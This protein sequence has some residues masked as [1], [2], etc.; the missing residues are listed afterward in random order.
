M[1]FRGALALTVLSLALALVV[2]FG[3]LKSAEAITAGEC[4]DPARGNPDANNIERG[5]SVSIWE[6]NA[7][8]GAN[9][10]MTAVQTH[11]VPPFLDGVALGNFLGQAWSGIGIGVGN[12]VFLIETGKTLGGFAFAP[13]TKD[14]PNTFTGIAIGGQTLFA[15]FNVTNRLACYDNRARTPSF[16][17]TDENQQTHQHDAP[18]GWNRRGW[19]FRQ[20]VIHSL[21]VPTP[22]IFSGDRSLVATVSASDC[23]EHDPHG[24]YWESDDL[25]LSSGE[26]VVGVFTRSPNNAAHRAEFGIVIRVLGLFAEYLQAGSRASQDW[27]MASG[28]IDLPSAVGAPGVTE[29]IVLHADF[30]SCPASGTATVHFDDVFVIR[31]AGGPKP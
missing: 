25:N 24:N 30:T 31:T 18:I 21:D 15:V 4:L 7:S 9:G 17:I 3:Q 6:W 1:L 13:L 26:H 19:G 29:H 14:T 10:R 27:G 22:N 16:E 5:N 23:G 12:R 8:G 2:A 20:G 28:V 11:F